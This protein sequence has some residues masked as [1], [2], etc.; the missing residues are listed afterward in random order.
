MSPPAPAPQRRR[1]CSVLPERREGGRHFPIPARR[2]RGA[3][4][5]P[6]GQA[7]RFALA[8]RPSPR[9]IWPSRCSTATATQTFEAAPRTRASDEPRPSPFGNTL[10]HGWSRRSTR[11]R[12]QVAPRRARLRPTGRPLAKQMRRS[13][14]RRSE[15]PA[16]PSIRPLRRPRPSPAPARRAPPPSLSPASARTSRPP[17]SDHALPTRCPA[18]F[19]TFLNFAF[20]LINHV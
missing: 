6:S 18:I 13:T 7:C 1:R 15:G 17:A 3:R 16:S 9:K 2:P 20:S 12:L 14:S 8:V 19:S 5:L 10:V 4:E 11:P